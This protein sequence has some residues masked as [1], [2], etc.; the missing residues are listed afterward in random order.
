M[1]ELQDHPCK[2]VLSQV[3]FLPDTPDITKDSAGLLYL[4]V[5][6]LSLVQDTYKSS[7][8]RQSEGWPPSKNTK[9]LHGLV[10]QE[11]SEHDSHLA[12]FYRTG[13]TFYKS[14]AYFWTDKSM[15]MGLITEECKRRHP[16]RIVI[17]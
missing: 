8:D 11:I 1:L 9:Q 14:V 10:L 2:L 16:E 3:H 13:D 4:P 17:K 15:V 6:A 5:V 12:Q 7:R